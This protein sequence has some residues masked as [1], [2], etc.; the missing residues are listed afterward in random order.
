MGNGECGSG[1]ASAGWA[2][3]EHMR[4]LQNKSLSENIFLIELGF[5]G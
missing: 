3:E 5:S 4:A 2:V 1:L